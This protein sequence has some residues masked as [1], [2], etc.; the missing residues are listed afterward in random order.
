MY[1]VALFGAQVLGLA[2]TVQ[3]APPAYPST[4]YTSTAYGYGP[5]AEP[6]VYAE[7]VQTDEVVYQEPPTLV[8]VE[9]DV[10][11]I[12]D[13]DE[14]VYYVDNYYWRYNY[15]ASVWYRSPSYAGGWA[16]VDRH[17]VPPRIVSRDHSHYVHYRGDR[18]ARMQ[19][20]P[21]PRIE[22]APPHEA[23][24]PRPPPLH[25]GPPPG[26][27][28]GVAQTPPP[29]VAPPAP[30]P[31]EEPPHAKAK[32]GGP[33]PVSPAAK[34]TAPPIVTPPPEP[35]QPKQAQPPSPTKPS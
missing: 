31:M 21:A 23:N 33:A 17:A 15:G 35:P 6:T 28:P 19:P 12:R 25:I 7:P 22:H 30:Q 13:A 2:C 26:P 20:A 8:L 3:E 9:P 27:R 18:D 32:G 34:P 16:Y 14:P 1:V 5:T 11:V 29:N 10:W 24:A 4:P